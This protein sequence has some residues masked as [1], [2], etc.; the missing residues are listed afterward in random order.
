M[1]R[2]KKYKNGIIVKFR[3]EKEDKDKYK[4]LCDLRGINMQDDFNKYIKSL[5]Q[6][7]NK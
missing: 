2:P 6:G 3:I 4:K 1:A 5:V 7:D